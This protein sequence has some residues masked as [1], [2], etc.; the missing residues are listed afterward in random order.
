M[1]G[2]IYLLKTEET[3]FQLFDCLNSLSPLSL[4]YP[5]RRVHE[6]GEW[7]RCNSLFS[8]SFFWISQSYKYNITKSVS[9]KSTLSLITRKYFDFEFSN[10]IQTTRIMLLLWTK[11]WDHPKYS[12]LKEDESRSN[13]FLYNHF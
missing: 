4:S 8:D 2:V 11:F 7:Y 9:S 10:T 12:Y 1:K 3:D 6:D 13:G 5:T